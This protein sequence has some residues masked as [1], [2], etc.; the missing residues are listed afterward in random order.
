MILRLL[1]IAALLFV[2]FAVYVRFAS[3]VPEAW[4]VDPTTADDP[5]AGGYLLAVESSPVWSEPPGAVMAALSDI[6]LADGA[7]VLAGEPAGA[8]MTFVSRS[9]VM[10]F[11]DYSSVMAVA[12]EGGTRLA[13]VSRLRFGASDLGVNRARMEAWLQRLSEGLPPL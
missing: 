7:T 4:H 12:G 11:P 9:K 5:G 13:I 10:G 3:S 6:A 1:L 8:H 2:L